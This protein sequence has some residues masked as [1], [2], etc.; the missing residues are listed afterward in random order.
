MKLLKNSLKTPN[1]SRTKILRKSVD[2]HLLAQMHMLALRDEEIQP[3]ALVQPLETDPV[4][5]VEGSVL[6]RLDFPLGGDVAEPGALLGDGNGV[7]GEHVHGEA[8]ELFQ[9]RLVSGVLRG[10]LV[11]D[12]GEEIAVLEVGVEVGRVAEVL[13]GDEIALHDVAPRAALQQAVPGAADP[14]AVGAVL[15]FADAVVLAA[16][17]EEVGHPR[18]VAAFDVAA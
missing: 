3:A 8:V 4:F 18:P 16:E 5:P 17:G 7:V 13:G 12:V 11:V 2:E 10:P 9:V 6:E 15:E 1:N 14:V